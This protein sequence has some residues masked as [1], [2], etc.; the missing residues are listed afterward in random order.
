MEDSRV[1]SSNMFVEVK[2]IGAS[3]A[4]NQA[5]YLKIRDHLRQAGWSA[6]LYYVL[7]RGHEC[8]GDWSLI[9]ND[10]VHVLLWEDILREALA[11]PLP[12]SSTSL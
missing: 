6:E 7:S 12:K 8:V 1:N 2:T 10:G 5:R 11:T 3:I 4:R 9:E